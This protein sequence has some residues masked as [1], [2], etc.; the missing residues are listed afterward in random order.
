VI[1]RVLLGAALLALTVFLIGCG[2]AP[3]PLPAAPTAPPSAPT[4]AVPA[5]GQTPLPLPPQPTSPAQPARIP[6]PFQT[7]APARIF[8]SSGPTAVLPSPT[9]GTA[10]TLT[11]APTSAIP[12]ASTNTPAPTTSGAAAGTRSEVKFTFVTPLKPAEEAES[13]E[14]VALRTEL[15]KVPGFIDITVASDE[16]VVTVGYDAGLISVDQL[17][18]KFEELK[19]PVK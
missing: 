18:L 1:Q 11:P 3:T 10:S 19:H 15:K 4:A 6:S 12:A 7:A 9:P 17:R 5:T 13:A 16:E 8:S 14:L 2:A